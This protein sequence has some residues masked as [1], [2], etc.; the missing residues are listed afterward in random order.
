MQGIELSR[1]FFIEIVQPWL[2]QV[3]PEL[4]YAAALIGYGSELLGFDDEMSKDHNWGRG[5]T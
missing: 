4:R 3:A 1:R 2:R 5:F